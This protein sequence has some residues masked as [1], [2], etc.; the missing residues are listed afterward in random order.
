MR[1][2]LEAGLMENSFAKLDLPHFVSQIL[3]SVI[4]LF[5]RYKE[6]L[7]FGPLLPLSPLVPL[8]PWGP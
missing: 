6:K 8:S 4:F 7:T 1:V 3:V 2:D 5:L